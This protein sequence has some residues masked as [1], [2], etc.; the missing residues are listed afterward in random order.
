[1]PDI[2]GDS[3]TTSTISVGGSANGSIEVGAD[4][5]WYRITLTAGQQVSISLDGIGAT[6]LEDPYIRLRDQSGA[7]IFEN[8]DG[9]P[10]RNALLSFAATYS[11]T[12]YIDVAAWD[13]DAGSYQYTGDYQL[14]VK[15]YT[16]PP[17]GTIDQFAAQLTTGYYEGETH[18]FNVTQ[19][20]SI[21][22]NLTGLTA[23][24]QTLAR[25]A[26]NEWS[27]LIGITFSEVATGGQ[28]IFDDEEEGAST[29]AAYANGIISSA[30]VNISKQWLTDYGTALNSYSYQTYVHEIGHALGLGHAGNYNETATFPYDALY[31]N[32]A[33]PMS[34]MSY[35]AQ[36]ENSYYLQRGFS[37]GYVG[38]PMLAD[39]VAMSQ[40][41]GLSTTLRTGNTTYG[42]NSTA[43][44]AIFDASQYT[45]LGLTIVDSGG[46]DTLDYSGYGGNQLINLNYDSF[47]NVLGRVGN[48]A[49]GR[50]TIIENAIGGTADDVLI[51]NSANN[52]LDG[53]GGAN[54]ISYAFAQAG[55]TINAGV[56][57]AQNTIGA[58]T[59][60]LLNYTYLIGSSF[61]D[62]LTA[63]VGA[64]MAIEGGAGNDTFFASADGNDG[65]SGGEGD[66]W[67]VDGPSGD[68]YNGGP[69]FDTIDYRLATSG[70]DTTAYGGGDGNDSFAEVEQLLGSA[71]DDKLTGVSIIIGG[72]GNDTV[73]VFFG[74]AR[75]EGGTGNDSF[76]VY[77]LSNQVVELAG[78]G[79]DT[80][81]SW[82]Y[83]HYVLP[84]NVENLTLR[85]SGAVNGSGNDI[86][87]VITG[88]VGSNALFG[89]AGNDTIYG[90]DGNDALVGGDGN[91]LLDG[92]NGSDTA[93][94]V[95]ASAGVI[96]DL[97]L[98]GAQNTVGA[99]TDTLVSIEHLTGTAFADTLT[100]DASGNLLRGSEGD[101][102]LYG[103]AGNDVLDGG[104]GNDW[105]YGSTGNDTYIVDS[106]SDHVIELISEGIDEIMTSINW[107][108]AVGLEIEGLRAFDA[109]S[110]LGLTLVGNDYAQTIS[111]TAGADL[112]IGSGGDDY[113]YGGNGN[114]QIDGGAGN[115]TLNGGEGDDVLVGRED[116][117]FLM[118]SGGNDLL[119][120]DAGNDRI[121][122]G[123][124][125]DTLNGGIGNDILVGREGDDL[126][127]GSDGADLL[128]GSD[129]ADRIDGGIG[130]DTLDGGE[131]DDIL[132]GRDDDDL[133]LGSGGN[134]LLIGSEG[135]DQIDGG[136]GADY[137]DGGQGNDVLVGREGN[138]VILG[139]G[140]A[141]LL[142]GLDG[143]D[144]MDGG[145]GD[146]Q[147]D[148]GE[149]NDV[150]NGGGGDDILVGRGGADLFAFREIGGAVKI[151]DF[152]TGLDRLDF[153][154]MD[155]N[156]NIAGDQAF[157]FIDGNAF[158]NVA[159]QLR[160][161][162]T[163]GV[164]YVAADVN[165]DSVAD[166]VIEIGSVHAVAGDILL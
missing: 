59:D 42:Y 101:D 160:E 26:L 30:T 116:D 135:N 56:T 22:V 98:A 161:Y 60:T 124:G 106:S 37:F 132:V 44:D 130:N 72:A 91:D 133:L 29:S 5:D 95:G 8:D 87:N 69:G 131:G 31:V 108:L 110:L 57:G 162:V 141:D 82:I 80:V 20:G 88:S 165:G 36:D 7:V 148:G 1:M 92:G 51:G 74:V 117:D 62:T 77:D 136:L 139:S 45:T 122:G 53:R 146:D 127:L 76:D 68:A 154:S 66:D 33:W 34:V 25:Q 107:S 138:D 121:D 54:T 70:V 81:N 166:F 49:I 6:A 21:S 75:F 84:A 149:G 150:L 38:T 40:L 159:G 47:S 145:S 157:T 137:I 115:D 4:H 27:G 55:V 15:T 58:G 142:I 73:G 71:F 155:A 83:D 48:L 103:L 156:A 104:A 111:G 32:D 99:G 151:L 65:F 67:F 28:V 46:T 114:D 129:G 10:G 90:N 143:D 109:A 14:A 100:G 35:F 52:V 19:G 163:G 86:A 144:L 140:G 152:T 13:D 153:Q 134:D 79:T 113:F 3:S 39:V 147:L 23:A 85:L 164:N 128:Y 93:S 2:P 41:Y 120:G 105:L 96:V 64:Y 17:V 102:N 126:L 89:Y 11:G 94:Y 112:L 61:N 125:A 97:R 78:E 18:H 16:P 9:G 12:Y 63:R 119:I 158:S 24:G 43:G 50:G 123:L 118:G